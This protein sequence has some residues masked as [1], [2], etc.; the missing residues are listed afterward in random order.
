MW[1][2]K[3]EIVTLPQI[4]HNKSPMEFQRCLEFPTWTRTRSL[5]VVEPLCMNSAIIWC[6]WKDINR[7]LKVKILNNTLAISGN[8]LVNLAVNQEVNKKVLLRERKRHTARRVASACYAALSN[9]WEGVPH[10]VLV[11]GGYTSHPPPSRPG[12]EGT[13]H[14]PDLGW[15]TPQ[16][17]HGIGYLPPTQPGMGYLPHPDLGWGTLHPQTWDGV[18]HPHKCGQTETITFPHPSD[19]GGNY[20]CYKPVDG[21]WDLSSTVTI[22]KGTKAKHNIG[23]LHI[24]PVT[25]KKMETWKFGGH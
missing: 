18:P 8:N 15:G 19:A 2:C 16:P 20:L 12:R 1:Y 22:P 21:A 14:H 4:R 6:N 3:P 17:R 24:H 7:N 25:W 11:V 13:S 9:G 23:Q 5:T 10:P